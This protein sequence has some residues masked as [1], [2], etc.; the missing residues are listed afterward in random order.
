MASIAFFPPISKSYPVVQNQESTTALLT[1][2]QG[3]SMHQLYTCPVSNI[4][5]ALTHTR[6][7]LR[8]F[9]IAGSDRVYFYT[10][11]LGQKCE[12]H[13]CMNFALHSPRVHQIS[14]QWALSDLSLHKKATACLSLIP[15]LRLSAVLK[16]PDQNVL[17]TY[18]EHGCSKLLL[19]VSTACTQCHIPKD[20]NLHSPAPLWEPNISLLYPFYPCFYA[21]IA[22]YSGKRQ[23]H[24]ILI[25]QEHA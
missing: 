16:M 2:D 11:N 18:P 7:T 23:L 1:L 13:R 19:C 4:I 3:R 6:S 24:F 14:I 10:I 12:S 20:C 25:L 17:S 5:W 22:W 21:Y 15:I 8:N 9:R